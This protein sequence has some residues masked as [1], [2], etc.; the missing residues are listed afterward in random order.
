MTEKYLTYN[1]L[2][3]LLGL[4]KSSVYR[5]IADGTLPKPIKIG[6]LRRFRKSDVDAALSLL[7]DNRNRD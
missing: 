6:H 2:M 4:C 3:G 5:R 1:E 7:S